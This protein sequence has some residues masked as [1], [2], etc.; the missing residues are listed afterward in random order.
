MRRAITFT[1]LGLAVGA[2]AAIGT[3]ERKSR[4][5]L[6]ELHA[7]LES[8]SV[9]ARRSELDRGNV[10]SALGRLAGSSPDR[11]QQPAKQAA[12]Q[13]GQEAAPAPKAPPP[14]TF[15]ESQQHVL[16][17]YEG[18]A[19]DGKWSAE[20]T[21]KLQ[22]IAREHLPERSRLRS[23]DC[24]ATMCRIEVFHG[25]VEDETPFLMN[26][27]AGWPGQILV[28][29]ESREGDGVAVTLIASRE[30][31]QPPIGQ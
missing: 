30:G 5:E 3:Y 18:E 21:Q 27:F 31:T 25:R 29:S 24:R 23:L 1:C 19:V 16:T 14:P 4:R 10:S 2:L 13:P 6:D 20:A 26:G 11:G 8:L 17:A 15:E 22:G 12:T 9:A 7:S 28:A